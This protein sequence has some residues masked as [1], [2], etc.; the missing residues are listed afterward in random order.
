MVMS[1]SMS[2]NEITLIFRLRMIAESNVYKIFLG[3][4][5]KN[6]KEVKNII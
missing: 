1:I 5:R 6:N 3:D 2:K 4:E